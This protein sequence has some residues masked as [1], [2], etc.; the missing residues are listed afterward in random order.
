MDSVQRC[1]VRAGGSRQHHYEWDG[2]REGLLFLIGDRADRRRC[3]D[4]RRCADA[5]ELIDRADVQVRVGAIPAAPVQARAADSPLGQRGAV[6]DRP[7]LAAPRQMTPARAGDAFRRGIVPAATDGQSG[8][9]CGGRAIHCP[10]LDCTSSPPL[11][12]V[13][14][15]GFCRF[16]FS[17]IWRARVGFSFRCRS[18]SSTKPSPPSDKLAAPPDVSTSRRG[19]ARLAFD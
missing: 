5:G 6:R 2:I 18:P 3:L 16:G 1:P 17:L 7:A 12:A 19:M 13:G 10:V 11:G 8:K 9:R 4:R 14:W 15:R